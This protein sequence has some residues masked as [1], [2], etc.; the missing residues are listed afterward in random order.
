M[1]K[2]AIIIALCVLLCTSSFAATYH[3]GQGCSD[4]GPGALSNPFCTLQKAANTAVAGDRILVHE[5][6]YAGFI[7]SQSGTTS[8]PIS[9][10]ADSNA[11][12]DTPGSNGEGIHI[13][14]S[15][16]ITIEGFT[17][18]L[19]YLCVA[20]RGATATNP[21]I[22]L[23]IRNNRCTYSAVGEGLNCGFYLSQASNS[24]IENNTITYT[25]QS[26]GWEHAFY[27]ANAGS[28]NTIIRGNRMVGEGL[29]INGDLSV[30]GDGVVTGLVIDDNIVE[31]KQATN[32]PQNGFSL[33]GVQSS[34]I[35]N[36]IIYGILRNGIRAFQVDGA[37][38]PKNLRIMNN[39]IV[40]PSISSGWAVKISEDGG[41][42]VVFNNVLLKE[43]SGGGSLCVDNSNIASDSNVVVDRFSRDGDSSTISLA[44]WK[45]SGLDTRSFQSTPAALFN[46]PGTGDFHLKSGSGAIDAGISSLSGTNA[47][48]RDRDGTLRP[49]GAAYDIGAYEYARAGC[50][51]S[52]CGSGES[53]SNCPADCGICPGRCGDGS[54]STNE[55]C[56]LCSSDCGICPASCGDHSCD[57]NE[58]CRSCPADCTCSCLPAESA[59]CD[60]CISTTELIEYITRWR[61]SGND[62]SM[63]QLMDSIIQ[64]KRGCA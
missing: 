52:D 18:N 47:P 34:V 59:P 58:T 29:H 43:G 33:D 10:Q 23:I 56:I 25:G 44:S 38:G 42:H 12:I 61:V 62:V 55:S 36:N 37:E 1:P 53:C 14:N 64:W 31:G 28:K 17:I 41:G 6:H 46:N 40:V 60:S 2:T 24:L 7:I 50:G 4:L 49:L 63:K 8:A 19:P 20:A 54:C 57:A 30:G 9:F 16:Y 22:G 45:S 35:E 32:G 27:L 21:M 11:I 3:V 5:G 39:A 26:T 51:D 48:A 15:N 13:Q